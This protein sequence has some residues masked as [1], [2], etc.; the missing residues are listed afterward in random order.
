MATPDL[1]RLHYR[2]ILISGVIFQLD[3]IIIETTGMADP[4]PVIQTFFVDKNLSSGVF[5]DGVLTVVDAKH[6][7]KHLH[8]KDGKE[9]QQQIAYADRIVLN[10]TDLVTKEE[11]KRVNDEIYRI[12]SSSRILE[13][14][15]A[16]VDMKF[17]LNIRAFEVDRILKTLDPEFLETSEDHHH[18]HHDEHDC[19]GS[20]C[21]HHSHEHHHEKEKRGEDD[22]HHQHQQQHGDP[23]EKKKE[24]HHEHQHDHH[25]DHAKKKKEKKHD[26]HRDHR[27]H[28]KKK[29]SHRHNSRHSSK[30]SSVGLT[31]KG[32]VDYD[33]LVDWL[34]NLLMKN[35]ETIYRMKGVLAMEGDDQMFVVQG[36]H[37]VWDMEPAGVWNSPD[38]TSK[39]IFIG[40]KLDREILTKGFETCQIGTKAHKESRMELVKMWEARAFWEKQLASREAE[41][42]AAT[43]TEYDIVLHNGA[44]GLGMLLSER[45]T[46]GAK[47]VFVAGYAKLPDGCPN[48][49]ID[50]GLI[51]PG[52]SLLS[53]NGTSLNGLGLQEVIKMIRRFPRGA[54]SSG[55]LVSFRFRVAPE[56]DDVSGETDAKQND[57]A[58]NGTATEGSSVEKRKMSSIVENG[59]SSESSSAEVATK[60]QRVWK[61]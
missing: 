39:M 4:A 46:N 16:K 60:R 43:D 49:A 8:D 20:S 35:G 41:A 40:E 50:S 53:I 47:E 34:T 9:A 29:H 36:T 5:L 55:A 17:L 3:G 59:T 27:H 19:E 57:V 52:D 44:Y 25:D 12:N 37:Q 10:K 33:V 54:G 42:L 21:D 14:V 61:G 11:L 23:A 2:F 28:S 1:T 6:I 30:V 22:E 32:E 58:E 56:D 51:L 45:I 18:H 15:Q 48:N 31:C 13:T 7:S 38:R 26:H 24:E